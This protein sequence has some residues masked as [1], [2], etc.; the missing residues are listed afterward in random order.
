MKI[1]YNAIDVFMVTVKSH[2]DQQLS[3]Q[4]FLQI[5]LILQKHS[6]IWEKL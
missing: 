4:L 2:I 3:S 5:I 1:L 6:G